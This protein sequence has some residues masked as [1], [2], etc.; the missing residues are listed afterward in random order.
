VHREPEAPREPVGEAFFLGC[1]DLDGPVRIRRVERVR[2]RRLARKRRRQ[3]RALERG[4]ARVPAAGEPDDQ[5]RRRRGDRR[6]Q[7]AP[8]R[9]AR[10]WPRRVE[11]ALRHRLGEPPIEHVAQRRVLAAHLRDL[12]GESRITRD[13]LLEREPPTFGQL[14]V[15]VCV[16]V[17][18]GCGCHR[19]FNGR[20]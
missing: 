9:T 2:E 11:Q 15:G 12:R 10:R 17:V 19:R 13:R 18:V 14:P 20:S 6:E 3:S 5:R 16:Q 8:S 1:P 7:A 4:V